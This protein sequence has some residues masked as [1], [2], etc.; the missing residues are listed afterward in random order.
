MVHNLS[1]SDTKQ[2]QITYIWQLS[3]FYVLQT[4]FLCEN[5]KIV[6]VLENFKIHEIENGY[7]R[8]HARD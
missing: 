1:F 3:Y 7:A 5:S 6:E 8:V 4:T 2:K